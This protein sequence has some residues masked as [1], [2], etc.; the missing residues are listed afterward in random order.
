LVINFDF[1]G[2]KTRGW[3]YSKKCFR[4]LGSAPP[5]PSDGEDRW[6]NNLFD[7][8]ERLMEMCNTKLRSL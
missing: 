1:Y 7:P 5:P 8:L 6:N 3:F 2:I 4:G